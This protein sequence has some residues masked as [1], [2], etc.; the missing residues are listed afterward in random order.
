MALDFP[1]A[2]TVGQKYPA[3]PLPGV[4]VYTWDGEKWTTIGGAV[5]GP[6]LPVLYDTAQTLTAPQQQQARQNIY[7]APFDALAYN[8]LQINGAMDISQ[9]NHNN[10]NGRQLYF[11][12][13]QTVW[14]GH[15]GCQRR[16]SCVRRK[17][18]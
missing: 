3:S 9:E 10:S 2:P 12:W 1:T 6:G 13:I 4:P 16:A 18:V 17:R 7:A 14:C 5:V 15:D 8:G 11:R